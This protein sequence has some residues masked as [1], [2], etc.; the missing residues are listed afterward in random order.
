MPSRGEMQGQDWETV[1]FGSSGA[2]EKERGNGRGRSKMAKLDAETEE[3]SHVKVPLSLQRAL[4]EARVAK[5]ITRK[6]LAS[7]LSVPVQSVEEYETGK[8]V[9]DN[10]FVAKMERELGVRLP[11]A[12]KKNTG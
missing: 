3:L 12:P 6:Q 11:R 8:C 7:K 2:K 9:P 5:G 1:R 4:S 10:S